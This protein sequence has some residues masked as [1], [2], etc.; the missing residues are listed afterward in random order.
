MCRIAKEETVKECTAENW[1]EFRRLIDETLPCMCR[2]HE[3]ANSGRRMQE[4]LFRGV[5]NSNWG[6]ETTLE[7]SIEAPQPETL[8]SYYQKIDRSKPAVES[9]TGKKWEDIPAWPEFR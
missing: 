2:E 6:L 4:P 8:G 7:R 1:D 3:Q 9:L 5:G